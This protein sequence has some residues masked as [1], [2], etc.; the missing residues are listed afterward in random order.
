VEGERGDCER[1]EQR[2][3]ILSRQDGTLP[4]FGVVA[5]RVAN[6]IAGASFELDGE[7]FHL[8][9]GRGGDATNCL[10]GG[11][12]GLDKRLWSVAR[13]TPSSVTLAYTSPAGEQGFPGAV[14]F[15][16][17]YDLTPKG[18]L[19][20]TFRALADAATPVSLTQHSYFNLDGGDGDGTILD[21]TLAVDADET[22]ELGAGAAPTG[23]ALPVSTLPGL[24]LRVPTRVRDAHARLPGPGGLDHPFLV[25]GADPGAPPGGPLR[26]A[27]L[28][29]SPATGRVLAVWT[30]AA[31]LQVY[32]GGGIKRVPGKRGA[33]HGPFAGVALETHAAPNAVNVPAWAPAV[34]LRPGREHR[35]VTE[36]RFGVGEEG[37]WP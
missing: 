27:A 29:R 20:C 36:Y 15:T 32:A 31:C 28:L 6:R 10:H 9:R 30:D 14:A 37:R 8:P 23:A 3:Q 4:F 22:L 26:R 13:A 2:K 34:V 17:S 18:A 7:T 24:D 11:A 19:R 1:K 33:T 12:R 35:S 25:R 16:V 5:G 21:H